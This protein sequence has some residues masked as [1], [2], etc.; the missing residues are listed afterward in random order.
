MD[1]L[2]RYGIIIYEGCSPSGGKEDPFNKIGTW[3]F[4]TFVGPF[5]PPGFGSGSSR[6]ICMRIRINNTVV[7]TQLKTRSRSGAFFT[8]QGHDSDTVK[9][10]LQPY[11]AIVECVPGHGGCRSCWWSL[12]EWSR[13]VPR[14]N[15][16][17]EERKTCHK[18]TY[19]SIQSRDRML[20]IHQFL[21]HGIITEV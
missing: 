8:Q 21:A 16:W 3:I 19:T 6:P 14:S 7:S 20:Q 5:G 10:N 13:G 9:E 15:A 2:Y 11:K 4:S 17:T 18:I 1:T 12:P